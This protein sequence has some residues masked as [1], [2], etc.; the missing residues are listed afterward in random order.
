LSRRSD[1]V[2]V[3]VRHELGRLILEHVKDPRLRSISITEVIVGADL[4]LARV[5]VSVLGSDEA[6]NDA[7]R[8]LRHARGFLRS[9]L[10]HSLSLK[11]VPELAF[12]L[13]RGAE[14]SVKITQILEGL[15]DHDTGS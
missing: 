3:L 8:A 1:R 9:S 14:H 7:M 13:D 12:E 15:H 11:A 2:A 4:R 6:R 10:A 5:Y